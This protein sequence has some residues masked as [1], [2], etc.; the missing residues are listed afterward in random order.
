[1]ASTSASSSADTGNN[2]ERLKAEGNALHVNGQYQGAY[3]KYSEAIK[4][5]PKNPVLWA[6]RAA[7]A[8]AMKK[9]MDATVDAEKATKL[10]PKYGKAWARQGTA[11]QALNIWE[12]SVACWE[13]ALACIPARGELT[14]EQ[15]LLKAQYEEGLK[16]AKAS[17]AQPLNQPTAVPVGSR[18]QANLP[19]KRALAME[20]ELLTNGRK[21]SS[22]FVILNAYR[23]FSEG[24]KNLQN[25]QYENFGEMRR[26]K[27][28]TGV[29]ASLTNG[30]LRDKRVFNFIEG[31]FF[32]K[33]QDQVMVEMTTNKAWDKGGPQMIK[34]EAPQRVRTKGWE[35]VRPALSITIRGWIMHGVIQSNLGL[36]SAPQ[37]FRHA[38]EVLEWGV[39]LW[40]DTPHDTRGP[41][42][43]ETF[44]RGVRRLYLNSLMEAW[45]PNKPEKHNLKDI[46]KLAQEILDEE[47]APPRWQDTDSGA[48]A[49]FWTYPKGD[50][51]A[52]LGWYHM[53]LAF[54]ALKIE[55]NMEDAANSFAT[56]ADY[57]IQAAN[58]F[59]KDDEYRVNYLKVALEAYWF[60]E[61][62]LMI[63]LP[64]CKE[65]REATPDMKRIWEHSQ[66]AERLG[67]WL[68]IVQAFEKNYR[69]LLSEGKVTL[70]E[71][72]RP[73]GLQAPEV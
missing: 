72:G 4:E 65:I 67:K 69:K 61:A 68:D 12:R 2:A 8:I 38:L 24:L 33:Y 41:I 60:G 50:A 23:D 25:L 6:N 27:G 51:L 19:W 70:E 57:Y 13:S 37:F 52:A 26:V 29:I 35:V 71:S 46:A 73:V 1:M 36:D 62:P 5:D 54:R 3:N 21:D 18:Q 44:I 58:S 20:R 30:I 17:M 28:H 63:T 43:D 32:E 14:K 7:S 59:Y 48:Y 66:A 11:F 53:K 49:S 42:F 55:D 9:Y 31:D 64:L 22:A 39:R 15:Q 40:K 16:K 56:S 10:D 45:K 34:D 47:Q